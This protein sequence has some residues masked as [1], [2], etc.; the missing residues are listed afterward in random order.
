MV[1]EEGSAPISTTDLS[2]R[3]SQLRKSSR[4]GCRHVCRLM[5]SL[6]SMWCKHAKGLDGQFF[7]LDPMKAD[8]FRRIAL[9]MPGA[10]EGAHMGH[11]D[12]RIS[13]HIFAT[14]G[15]PDERFGVVVLRPEEQA[16]FTRSAPRVF[17]P[18]KGGWGRR[19]ST[20]V[21]LSAA[22]ASTVR[23]AMAAAWQQKAAIS[24][25]ATKSSSGKQVKRA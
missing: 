14:I 25:R 20:K 18:V 19:G 21:N 16:T 8:D 4:A 24:P 7:S 9:E 5:I 23:K 12:F 17:T 1:S 13:G 11:A 15:Y 22:R 2:N 3:R 6:V 10:Y